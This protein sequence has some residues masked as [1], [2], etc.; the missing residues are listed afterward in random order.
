ML[1]EVFFIGPLRVILDVET[2]APLAVQDRVS[3]AAAAL[4]DYSSRQI[5]EAITAARLAFES[6]CDV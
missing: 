2:G 4:A 6:L 3:G 1:H 5:T